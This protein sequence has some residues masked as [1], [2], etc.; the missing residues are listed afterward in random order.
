MRKKKERKRGI[1]TGG[2]GLRRCSDGDSGGAT[3]CSGRKWETSREVVRKKKGAKCGR[4]WIRLVF[5]FSD[6]I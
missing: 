4:K 3:W 5:E 6:Q 2:G 1:L